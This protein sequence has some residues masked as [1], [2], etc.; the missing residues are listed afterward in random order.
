MHGLANRA[1]EGFARDTYGDDTWRRVIGALGLGYESFE[2][3]LDY[4]PDITDALIEG[5]ATAA[6]LSPEE[7]L[8]DLGTFLVA[9]PRTRAIRRLLR[10]GG[11]DFTDF[12]HSLGDLPARVR[13]ALPDLSVPQLVLEELGPGAYR[14]RVQRGRV[15]RHG[16]GHVMVGLLRAMADDYG[17]LVLLEHR[18]QDREVEKI[19]I[20]LLEPA[21]TEARAF[22]L[23]EPST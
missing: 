2:A 20:T 1:L 17:A 21:F 18:G 8:E 11:A 22:A 15:L 5:L 6:R 4:E 23:G 3:V 19:G 7:L 12:L 16:F 14:L 13:L 10:F 9:A